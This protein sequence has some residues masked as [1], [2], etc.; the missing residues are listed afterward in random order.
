[1]V[2]ARL[3][4]IT[5]VSG[6]SILNGV[7]ATR[8]SALTLGPDGIFTNL[9]NEVACPVRAF[10]QKD[11]RTRI[12]LGMRLN[13]RNWAALIRD[14]FSVSAI[15]LAEE[16]EPL[17]GQRLSD[18]PAH[19][20]T[21]PRFVFCATNVGTGACWHFH[22]GPQSRMGDFYAGYCD[23]GHVKVSEAVAA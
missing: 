19:G 23:A 13:P 9:E 20:P 3:S 7:L 10:C 22:G 12:L 18:L 5:S 16:Y 8:W 21:A 6:G 11:L 14:R 17:Y 1:G 2:L 4:T 15:F